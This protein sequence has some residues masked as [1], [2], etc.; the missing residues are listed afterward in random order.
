MLGHLVGESVTLEDAFK[1]NHNRLI[2]TGLDANECLISASAVSVHFLTS[3]SK[4]A[5][6]VWTQFML[7]R[8]LRIVLPLQFVL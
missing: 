6:Y 1:R 7:S 5:E 2:T 4:L 8:E 3:Q